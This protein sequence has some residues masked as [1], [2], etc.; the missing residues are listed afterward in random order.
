MTLNDRVVEELIRRAKA[1]SEKAHCPESNF[2]VGAAVLTEDGS[3][4]EGCNV[5][6]EIYSLGLCAERNAI[7]RMVVGGHRK[8]IAVAVSTPTAQPVTPCGGCLQ[9]IHEFGPEATVICQGV[10]ARIVKRMPELLPVSFDK[11]ALDNA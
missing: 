3:I 9:V 5:E 10:E 7:S 6:S 1:A 4:I 11:E 2:R 8:L